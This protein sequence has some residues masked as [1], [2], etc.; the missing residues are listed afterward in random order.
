MFECTYMSIQPTASVFVGVV[1]MVSRLT[2]LHW[3]TL[4]IAKCDIL[5]LLRG[6]KSK[7]MG[8]NI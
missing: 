6:K 5:K 8:I 4:L 7:I 3:T 2:T 1:Y